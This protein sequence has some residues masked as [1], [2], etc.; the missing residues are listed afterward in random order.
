MIEESTNNAT[1]LASITAVLALVWTIFTHVK[2]RKTESKLNTLIK[3][4]NST[5]KLN[6]N[7]EDIKLKLEHLPRFENDGG[8]YSNQDGTFQL[9]FKNVGKRGRFIRLI[10]DQNENYNVFP[11]NENSIFENGV[12][13]EMRG[14]TKRIHAQVTS[15]EM[16]FTLEYE[17]MLG[18]KYHQHYH[19]PQNGSSSITEPIEINI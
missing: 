15:I 17:D 3:E 18:N 6:S 19:R 9:K 8:G 11:S 5:N 16:K 7:R 1:W 4:F 2:S 12:S 13:L 10:N 14:M